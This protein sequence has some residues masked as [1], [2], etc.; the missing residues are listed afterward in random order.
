M[1]FT[2][3]VTM[4][5]P[6]FMATCGYHAKLLPRN[7]SHTHTDHRDDVMPCTCVICHVSIVLWESASGQIDAIQTIPEKVHVVLT[8]LYSQVT[9][10]QV[11]TLWAIQTIPER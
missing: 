8:R 3:V 9:L 5:M 11:A 7:Q 2:T 6:V 4:V 10:P 1:I